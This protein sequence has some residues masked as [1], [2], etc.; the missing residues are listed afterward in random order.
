MTVKIQM[1]ANFRYRDVSRKGRPVH[2]PMDAFSIRHP[3]MPLSRRAKIFSP[4]DALEGFNEAI[5]SKD[6]I[7]VP[8]KILSEDERAELDR[9]VLLLRKQVSGSGSCRE[10]PLRVRLEYFVPCSDPA[11]DAYGNLGIYMTITGICRGVDPVRRLIHI[12]DLEIPV[13]RISQLAVY[14]GPDP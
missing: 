10:H 12:D 9:K 11:S 1:P 7:Y 3:A 14:D 4:F 6:I 5:A 2:A 8:K 13:D